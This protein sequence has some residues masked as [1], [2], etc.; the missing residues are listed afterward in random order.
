VKADFPKETLHTKLVFSSTV[1][2]DIHQ[3]GWSTL[4][5]IKYVDSWLAM[6]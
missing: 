6:G 5:F 3:N 2:F 1:S 4:N